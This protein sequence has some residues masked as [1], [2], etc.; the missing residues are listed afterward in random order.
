MFFASP[1]FQLIQAKPSKTYAQ[2]SKDLGQGYMLECFI[3][4][5]IVKWKGYLSYLLGFE[6]QS[7]G[8]S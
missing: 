1:K 8:I 2:I 4:S 5:Y 3:F 6:N 7:F